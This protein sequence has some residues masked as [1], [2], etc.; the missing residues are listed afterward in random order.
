MVSLVEQMVV[1][2]NSRLLQIV[3]AL[4]IE[5]PR[6][7]YT[8]PPIL[9][10]VDAPA[11]QSLELFSMTPSSLPGQFSILILESLRKNASYSL[12][13]TEIHQI[14]KLCLILVLDIEV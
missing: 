13:N 1:Q 8:I 10:P 12:E 7:Q 14:R 2:Y 4:Y 6:S 5:V 11:Y 3:L 9:A